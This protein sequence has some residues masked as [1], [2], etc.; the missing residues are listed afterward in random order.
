MPQNINIQAC[1]AVFPWTV[2]IAGSKG[3]AK[4]EI[5]D[6]ENLLKIVKHY[7]YLENSF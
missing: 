1:W 6:M 4:R 7:K 3:V 5:S 2:K